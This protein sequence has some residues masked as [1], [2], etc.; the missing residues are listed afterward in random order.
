MLLLGS[1]CVV[2][3][4]AAI[5][6]TVAYW[7]LSVPSTLV[8]ILVG[9]AGTGVG[10]SVGVA[11]GVGSSVGNGGR[12]GVGSPATFVCNRDWTVASMSGVRATSVPGNAATTAAIT[13]AGISA[14]AGA[15]PVAHPRIARKTNNGASRTTRVIERV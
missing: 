6:T 3:E 15:C 2:G 7:N 8:G 5:G 11:V 13:V 10:S 12:V 9:V 14:V 1:Y 4:K